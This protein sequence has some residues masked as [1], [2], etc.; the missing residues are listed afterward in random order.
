MLTY[1]VRWAKT[2]LP[3]LD[4]KRLDYFAIKPYLRL[5]KSPEHS[6]ELVWYSSLK[7]KHWC[8]QIKTQEDDRW[9]TLL[10][11]RGGKLKIANQKVNCFVTQLPR[12]SDQEIQYRVFIDHYVVFEGQFTSKDHCAQSSRVVAFGDFG[13]GEI[14]AEQTAQA[15]VGVK[16][17]LLVLLGD[18][19][20]EYG[21]VLEYLLYFFP[22]LAALLSSLVAAAAS[23]NHDIGSRRQN[24]LDR[25]REFE[26]LFGY[27][28]FWRNPDNGPRLSKES[29][30]RLLERRK[31]RV[32]RRRFGKQFASLTNYSFDWANSHWVVLDANKFMDW[33][34]PELQ[35][36]LDDDLKQST[37]E[38]KIVCWHQ[39]ALCSDK[40]YTKDRRMLAIQEILQDNNVVLVLSGH[41]HVFECS[42]PVRR[43][44]GQ[45]KILD[46]QLFDGKE[47]TL[48]PEG[49]V[50]H[51]VSGAPSK[52]PTEGNEPEFVLPTTRLLIYDQ[53]S[54]TQLD[55]SPKRLEVSQICSTD[56]KVLDNF[57]ITR[58]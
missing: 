53:N 56:G 27:Y 49:Y 6:I 17:D 22:V 58:P 16:P 18:L 23:G 26:D 46:P 24:E 48:L 19:V 54:F 39:P 8:V 20:Y 29:R 36:W 7:R 57:V 5:G 25:E 41:S 30:K 47:N 55:F 31:G 10:P 35:Q 32:L 42:Y 45:L 50:I 52:L 11:Q 9:I 14:A 28:E 33:T 12:L 38:F 2:L 43:E 3:S 4:Q 1:I 40:S 13:D 37:A 34:L 21:R 44:D 51:L 15:V